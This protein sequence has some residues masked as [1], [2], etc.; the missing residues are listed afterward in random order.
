M[1]TLCGQAGSGTVA[2]ASSGS[3]SVFVPQGFAE[4]RELRVAVG[5]HLRV[6]DVQWHEFVKPPGCGLAYGRINW[7][8]KTDPALYVRIPKEMLN[9]DH[10]QVKGEEE[11]EEDEE[12]EGFERGGE[13]GGGRWGKAEHMNAIHRRHFWALPHLLTVFA[14][15]VKP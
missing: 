11:D 5:A 14:D 7:E 12:D 10:E 8:Y 3:V 2:A 6:K 13:G 4:G 1:H 15:K 9:L